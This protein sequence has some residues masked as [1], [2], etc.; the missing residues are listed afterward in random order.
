MPALPWKE[1]QP[2]DPG[3]QYAAM[4]SRLPLLAHRSIPGFLLDAMRIRGQLAH[5]PGLVGYALNAQPARKTFWTIS[6]W[7]DEASLS[8]FAAADPHRTLTKGLRPQMG[9]SHFEFFPISGGDLPLNWD[10]VRRRLAGA[11]KR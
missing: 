2:V 1:F 6:V 9:Q 7:T 10:E 11:E 3:R 5:A 4:A 8:T